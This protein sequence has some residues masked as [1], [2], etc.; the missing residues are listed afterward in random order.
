MPETWVRS[1]G[2]EDPL[3]KNPLQYSCLGNPVDRGASPVGYD[4]RGPTES[5]KTWCLRLHT[6]MADMKWCLI[7]IRSAFP[8]WL[9]ELCVFLCTYWSGV[10]L[11]RRSIQILCPLLVSMSFYCWGVRAL[12]TL[13]TQVLCH[14]HGL[15]IFSL[16]LWV[17]FFFFFC[18]HSESSLHQGSKPRVLTTGLPGNSLVSCLFIF[19]MVLW[20]MKGFNFDEDYFV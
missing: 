10:F 6:D 9:M 7:A 5:D 16:L 19:L 18:P 8:W 15:Q 17:V 1:L 14:I 2:W 12:H 11:S 4:P 13:W 20:S 3:E